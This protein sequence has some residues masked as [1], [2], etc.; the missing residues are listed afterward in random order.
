MESLAKKKAR[1]E[2]INQVLAREY[3][4]AKCS[5]DFKNPFQL[6]SATILSAQCTDE[7]VNMVTPSLFKVC[8]TPQKMA[9]M[10]DADLEEIVKTTGFFRN[11]TKSLKGMA[12]GLLEKFGGKVPQT[13]D[14]LRQLPGVGRKTANVVLGNCFNTPGLTIDTHMNRVNRRLGLSRH[15]DPEKIELDLMKLIPQPEWTNYSHRIIYHGRAICQA[16]KPLCER[17]PVSEYCEYY[18]K[19]QRAAVR[20]ASAPRSGP[21]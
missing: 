8:P 2:A 10:P 20:K 19:F 18:Q 7:R 13:M 6:L 21:R 14:E 1:A 15:E 12:A 4:N 9:A 3:P 17:C 11:K 16:R 5:L